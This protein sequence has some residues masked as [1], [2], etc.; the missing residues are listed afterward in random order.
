[1]YIFQ[2]ECCGID[3][4]NDYYEAKNWDRNRT[5]YI[6]AASKNE[7][8]YLETPFSCCKVTGTFPDVEPV[9]KQCAKDPDATNSN[10][11]TVSYK[12]ENYLQIPYSPQL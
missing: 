2:F 5:V 8:V 9:D 4:V 7:T 10:K 3:N 12:K 11:D 1:M 6:E